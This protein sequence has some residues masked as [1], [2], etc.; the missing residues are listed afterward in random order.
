LR[1][2]LADFR[3]DIDHV[4]KVVAW[5]TTPAALTTDMLPAARAISCGCVV[6]LSGYFESFI[7]ECMRGF[8]TAVNGLGKPFNVLPYNMRCTHFD[9]G[10]KALRGEIKRDRENNDT[11]NAENMAERLRSVSAGTGYQLVWEAFADTQ[12]NPGPTVVKGLINVVGVQDPWRKINAATTPPR[13]D[14]ETFLRI[15]IFIRNECAHTGSVATPPTASVL[16]EYGENL[17]AIG[18]GVV[19]LLES[20]LGEIRAL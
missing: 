12:A 13:G 14:L 4:N 6:L 19:M 10:G 2:A 8:I 7:K 15:F 9:K 5:L 20:R 16:T 1:S 17:V 18:E 11:A 3:V